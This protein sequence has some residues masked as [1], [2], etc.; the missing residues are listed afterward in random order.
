MQITNYPN[1]DE[2]VIYEKLENGLEV[3][4]IPKKDYSE[5]CAVFTTKFGGLN[6]GYEIE[7]NNEVHKVLPGSAHFL[8][9]RIFDYKG[10][11]ILQEFSCLG[12]SI[13]AYTS[14]D[15]TCYFFSTTKNVKRCLSLLLDF[16]QEFDV[17]SE[18]VENEKKIIEQ[19]ALMDKGEPIDLLH[20]GIRNILLKN[21]PYKEEIV[22]DIPSIYK[23]NLDHLKACHTKFYH[24]SNMMLVIVGK[25]DP[26][27]LLNEIK[28]N[29]NNK[30]FNE[31]PFI[32]KID[33]NEPLNVIKDYDYVTTNRSNNLVYLAYKYESLNHLKGK[34]RSKVEKIYDIILSMLFDKTSKVNQRLIKDKIINIDS[35]YSFSNFDQLFYVGVYNYQVFDIDEYIKSIKYVFDNVNEFL[36]DEEYLKTYKKVLLSSYINEFNNLLD[37]ALEITTLLVDDNDFFNSIEVIKS[38]TYNDII[39]YSKKLKSDNYCIY[40]VKGDKND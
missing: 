29:Q 28:E 3:Y 14:L 18:S 6:T 24:P 12:A 7:Y 9:H 13:N 10:R 33:Y 38:I 2:K 1:I 20:T 26:S 15:R 25:M 40:V 30:T 27:K 11:D 39:E 31:A 5:T 37:L 36:L 34:E 19:E 17:T 35:T 16:V 4:L 8:E 22:G 23:I 32:N 21:H